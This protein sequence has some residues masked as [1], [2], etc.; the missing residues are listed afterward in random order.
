VAHFAGFR[1]LDRLGPLELAERVGGDA[2]ADLLLA[3][4]G[5]Q[6][7]R[8]RPQQDAFQDLSARDHGFS[9]V[10]SNQSAVPTFTQVCTCGLP[11][12]NQVI[13]GP[14]IIQLSQ[15]PSLPRSSSE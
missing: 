10:S 7:D 15:I 14:W 13:L 5:S 3:S 4:P 1:H 9:P 12:K 8:G 11:R 2:E 6:S